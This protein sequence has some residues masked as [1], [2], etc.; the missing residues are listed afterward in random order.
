MNTRRYLAR[1]AVAV[2]LLGLLAGLAPAMAMPA[3]SG[4]ANV[5]ISQVYGGGGNSG[6][7]YKN[8]FVELF[9]RGAEPV[10]LAGWSI[11][12][13]SA[14]GAGN[15]GA[16][17]GQ[18][19]ELP[20]VTLEPGQYLLIQE[21]QG[22]GGSVDLPAPD[23]TDSTPINMSATGGKVALVNTAAPL[24]C[25]GGSSPCSEDARAKIVDLVGWD[26]AN[27]YEGSGPAPATGNSTAIV[28]AG[29]GCTD[30]DNNAA[31]FSAA[32]PAP[33]NTASLRHFCGE[34]APSVVK[35]SPA[36]G[37]ACVEPDA[38][39]SVTFSEPVSV[40]GDWFTIT[41]DK[42]GSHSASVRGGPVTFTLDPDQDLAEGDYCHVTIRAAA[43]S[44]QDLLDPPDTMAADYEWSFAAITP[45]TAIHSIQGAGHIS[46]LSGQNV[47][48]V[49]G[50]VTAKR[51]TG[52]YMQDP[53]PDGNE[54]TSEGLFVYT[55]PESVNVGDLV[56]V[57]GRVS[58]YR[59]G[60]KE[61]NLT[62]TE[63]TSARV[64]V[65][66]SGNPLPPPVVIGR[67][68]RV[69]P[70]EVIEDDASDGNV[71]TSGVFD[72]ASDGIDFYESL[73][74][75]LVELD[76]PVAVGP[77]A[78]RYGEL[79]VVGDNGAYA[80][81]RT[82]RGG[83]VV[84]P[85]DFNPER[86]ILDDEIIKLAGGAMPALNVGGSLAGPVLGVM[87]YDY[88]NFMIE[89][90]QV[91]TVAA[92]GLA[93]EVTA[94]AGPDQLAVAAFNVENLAPSDPQ[95]KFDRL[96]NLIVHN[97]QAPD[98]ISVEEIQDDSGAADDGVVDASLT[99]SK[100]IA[101]IQAAGGPAYQYRQ[102]DPVND[103]DGG[104]PGGNIRQGFLFRTD[105][106]LSFVDRPGGSSTSGVTVL[107]GPLGAELSASP[108]RIAP[109]DS[110]FVD[111]RKPLAGEFVFRGH[112]FFAIA[113]HFSSKSGDQPLFGR[114]QPPTLASEAQRMQQARVV[115]DFVASLL[116]VEPDADVIV[117]GDLNDFQFS[118][119][120]MALKGDILK[121]LVDTLPEGERYSYVY[122]GNSETLDHILVSNHLFGSVPYDY[123]V[124][125]VNAEFA[126][127]AS[128]HDPQVVRLTLRPAAFV[129]G[130][131]WFST[132]AGKASFELDGKYIGDMAVPTGEFSLTLPG[133]AFRST[134][135][136][137]LAISGSVAQL[138]GTGT[139]EGR[140]GTFSFTVTAIDGAAPGR[141][142]DR[143]RV[144]LLA[145][146]GTVIYDNM[147][148]AGDAWAAP[149]T[150]ALG[151]GNITI[152]PARW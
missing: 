108:G 100:L 132:P 90:T 130:G 120:I 98:L 95:A 146:D 103:E 24:G 14:T 65:L 44:D 13:A 50:I 51:G 124:V 48:N 16:S 17:S 21:A 47:C 86:I 73:E 133:L 36:S 131:G 75:M 76:D 122:E 82:P 147:P 27:F 58:E 32:S 57:S 136:Q 109:E 42:S 18:I 5:V 53:N 72:P 81:V 94:P 110:A 7:T 78:V 128:D 84:R 85:G 88:G 25:N 151:G 8:D 45:P 105:R 114:Y 113:N 152:H 23:V 141:G 69:P 40:T 145:A 38:Q 137:R 77:T 148:G 54:A 123:D 140:D 39:I 97:L 149:E 49:Q 99:Y 19:T 66:S 111:S 135:C 4:S 107:S 102:I 26:G 12:Y 116:A 30:T 71:E 28:R 101:A 125:H 112:K 43:V 118:A 2:L 67:G 46:P 9:N 60:G 74:G 1:L 80:A 6:A 119:P 93:P 138:V 3:R 68:G 61:T 64:R 126:D 92:N 143:L 63:L 144:Q 33:R 87:D 56:R 150:P 34:E 31:D 41:C 83:V 59:P 20:A 55:N 106:G 91:P 127:Q 11:Q 70:G 89:L 104:A 139:I 35:T 142:T 134:A 62:V 96:A 121:D 79:P 10:S 117:L 37:A 115:H 52:F 22:S 29:G 15:F 129:T